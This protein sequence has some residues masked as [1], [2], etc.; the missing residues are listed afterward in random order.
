MNCST[1]P[2]R[3]AAAR[4]AA[5]FT[6]TPL[7]RPISLFD[8]ETDSIHNRVGA[9][10][11]QGNR[12][13]IQD[14][15]AD[16]LRSP[17]IRGEE[18]GHPIRVS[19]YS[20]DGQAFFQK[21]SDYPAPQKAGSAEDGDNSLLGPTITIHLSSPPFVGT[22]RD[23]RSPMVDQAQSQAESPVCYLPSGRVQ[24]FRRRQHRHNQGMAHSALVQIDLS[25]LPSICLRN[26][27]DCCGP[28]CA[29]DR[30]DAVLTVY[31]RPDFVEAVLNQLDIGF[32][33]VE[34]CG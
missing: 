22:V 24:L 20:T 32:S 15:G 31:E 21:L 18:C 13:G 5:A 8:I 34:A 3:E 26:V 7:K 25:K 11:G 23:N 2:V 27:F 17:R 29:D 16:G 6:C 30:A 4:S 12:D 19:G 10:D 33:N 9:G 14:N 1:L 28:R